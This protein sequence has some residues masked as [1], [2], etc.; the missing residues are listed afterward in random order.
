[1]YM[2]IYV[3]IHAHMFYIVLCRLLFEKADLRPRLVG[4]VLAAIGRM[5]T[6]GE[7]PR[8]SIG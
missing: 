2:Y 3:Y 1:M 6:L 4:L 8:L 7:E 5:L